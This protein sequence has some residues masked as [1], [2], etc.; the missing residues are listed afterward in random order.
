MMSFEAL[1][2]YEFT[3]TKLQDKT[4]A[5]HIFKGRGKFTYEEA[6]KISAKR[7]LSITRNTVFETTRF[8][9]C[10]INDPP[11]VRDLPKSYLII[12]RFWVQAFECIKN[13]NG[14]W[15]AHDLGKLYAIFTSDGYHFTGLFYKSIS[16]PNFS[17]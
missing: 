4:I 12:S 10:R 14:I 15:K 8:K 5:K 17:T 16:W 13:R 9:L 2:V 6:I 1:H 3:C 11:N 7:G